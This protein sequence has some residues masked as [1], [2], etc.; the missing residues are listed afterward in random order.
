MGEKKKPK[1]LTW[2]SCWMIPNNENKGEKKIL[3]SQ[4]H[5]EYVLYITDD[6][7]QNFTISF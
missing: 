7:G 3:Y 5:P 4:Q 6:H 1:L 2:F